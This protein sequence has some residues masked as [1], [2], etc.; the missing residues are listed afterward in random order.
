MKKLDNKKIILLVVLILV[1]ALIIFFAIK[2]S[3]K[4]K[5]G[6]LANEEETKIAE[7]ATIDYITKLTYG[8]GTPYNGLDLLYSRDS[9]TYDDL[10]IGNVLTT[11]FEYAINN[12]ESDVPNTVI[13]ALKKDGFDTDNMTIINGSSV[14]NAIKKIFGIDFDNKDYSAGINYKFQYFYNSEFDVYLRSSTDLPIST[15]NTYLLYKII[16]TTTNNDKL[17]TELAVAYVYFYNNKYYFTKD[18]NNKEKVYES[19][20]LEL[21]K[22]KLNEFEHFTI[23]L[24]K[25]NDDYVF[26]KISKNK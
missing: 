17:N 26:E 10:T 21:Q 1:I 25:V 24:K 2:Q 4:N 11:A 12:S 20:K 18:A 8:Q 9:V 13:N 16:K 23:T 15:D 22:D 14:R 19:D 5:N 6:K 7:N 3:S